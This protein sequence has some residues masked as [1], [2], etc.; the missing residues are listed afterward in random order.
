[1]HF[2]SYLEER[3]VSKKSIFHFGSGGHHLVGRR[4]RDA[5][6][7][8]EVLAITASPREHARYV[9]KVTRDPSLGRHYRVLFA[10]I[11]D[12]SAA[13]LP[14]FDVVTLFHLFEYTPTD[15]QR[16]RLDDAG[17][18]D[19]FRSKLTRHGRLLFYEG[20][21]GRPRTRGIIERAVA[22]GKISFE[23]QYKSLLIYRV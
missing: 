14:E 22:D 11:Y 3:N 4:N 18:L 13:S 7:E 17:V 20:S 12:L 6:L 5:A 10:D 15:D 16:R 2:C 19:L 23:E 9:K 1:V 8:N 21:I